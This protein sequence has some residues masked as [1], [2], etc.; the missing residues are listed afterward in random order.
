[1]RAPSLSHRPHFAY[2]DLVVRILKPKFAKYRLA[3]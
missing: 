2:Q 1:M 3:R